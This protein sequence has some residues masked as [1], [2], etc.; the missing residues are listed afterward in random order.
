MFE[1]DYA[2]R[3]ERREVD[4]MCDVVARNWDEPVPYRASDLSPRGMWLDS[5]FPL[6]V[7]EIAH[8]TVRGTRPGEAPL[9]LFARVARCTRTLRPLGEG[10]S[11]MGLEFLGVAADERTE[12]RRRLRG[13]A[14]SRRR[15]KLTPLLGG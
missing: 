3:A 8:V 11:G 5:T 12:L 15:G 6:E 14:P 13:L 4:V 1:L 10:R 7:G 9:E 2:R